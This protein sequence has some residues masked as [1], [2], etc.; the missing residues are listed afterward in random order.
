MGKPRRKPKPETVYREEVVDK[1]AAAPVPLNYT[2][3]TFDHALFERWK[4][5]AER[6]SSLPLVTT[7]LF[8]GRIEWEELG[9]DGC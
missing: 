6:R 7:R 4:E 2:R 3:Q 9:P 8:V 1:R 5:A